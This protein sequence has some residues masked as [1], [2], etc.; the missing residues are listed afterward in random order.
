VITLTGLLDLTREAV[1]AVAW[2]GEPLAIGPAA[3]ERV[4]AG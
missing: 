1:E 4:A 2:G 3:L